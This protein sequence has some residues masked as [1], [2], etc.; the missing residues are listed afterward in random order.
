[1]PPEQ[2]GNPPQ[3]FIRKV[4]WLKFLLN[5]MPSSRLGEQESENKS[6]S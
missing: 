4:S 3:G 5:P 6:L 2:F 1:M